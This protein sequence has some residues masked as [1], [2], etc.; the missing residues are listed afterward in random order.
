MKIGLQTWGTQGDVDPFF[1]LAGALADRGHQVRLVVTTQ[2][3]RKYPAPPGVQLERVGARM[4]QADGDAL[5]DRVIGLSSPMAQ[6]RLLLEEGFLPSE[7]EMH[8]A[9]QALV[10]DCDL[11]VRHHFL[12]MT[13]I[14][15]ERAET[16]EVS[17][18]FTPDL[19][20]TKAHP[21]TGMPSLGPL[22]SVGWWLANKGI[23]SVFGPPAARLR[24][25]AGLP[26]SKGV[27]HDVWPSATAN[28]IAVSP[29][30][31][32]RP[33]D[34]PEQHH[35]TGFWRGR[36][37][38]HAQLAPELAQFLE[39]GSP[40][41]YATFG[42][43]GGGSGSR[44][45]ENASLL[46]EAARQAGRRLVLQQPPG[47]PPTVGGE[48]VLCVTRAPHAV[49]FPRCA[50]VIH[51]GGAGTTQTAVRAGVP[52][53]VV[54]H[55]ADQFF[56]AEQVQRLGVGTAVRGRSKVK[57]AELAK[58]IERAYNDGDARRRAKTLAQ[59]L[60]AEDGV[61]T[62]IELLEGPVGTLSQS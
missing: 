59:S 47:E 5:F 15:A 50:A 43:M 26:R 39:S 44:R 16:P 6:G 7:A 57:V 45:E 29:T 62:A 56:W 52:S 10:A 42:S 20:P 61:R 9:A 49:V 40:P 36:T 32:P 3:D 34:W 12:Y 60:E 14:A 38:T 28:L 58:A 53:V 8:E 41:V 19:L 37:S 33:G 11:V 48:D 30:L 2:A 23:S 55:L 17:V 4:A 21:P 35:L 25:D 1:A 18:F 46:V 24:R 13:R 27:L 54:P 51:H 31:F 22:Q